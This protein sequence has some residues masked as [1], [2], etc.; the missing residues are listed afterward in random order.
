MSRDL[1]N[2]G[3][4]EAIAQKRPNAETLTVTAIAA[5]IAAGKPESSLSLLAISHFAEG[6]T[7]LAAKRARKNISDLVSL[8]TQ[9][10]WLPDADGFERKVSVDSISP[11]MTV[12]IHN[13]EKICVD[14]EI[15]HSSAAVDQAAIT[16]ESAPVSKQVGDK[17]FAGTNIRLGDIKVRVEKVG[18]DT[19]LARIVHM[20]E[21]AHSRRAPIQNYANRMAASLVPVSFIAAAVVYLATRDIA[22]CVKHALY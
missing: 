17:V 22:A 16:G 3:I 5:S 21:D 6:L 4:K 10:V 12:C 11:G 13:G 20:V 2:S 18:D 7:T 8:D 19:S 9:E 14:G 1:L 15:I